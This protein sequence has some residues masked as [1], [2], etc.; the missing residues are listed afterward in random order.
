MEEALTANMEAVPCEECQAK[1]GSKPEPV[2]RMSLRVALPDEEA[3]AFLL[4]V[5]NLVETRGF[6]LIS[7]EKYAY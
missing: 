7:F 2:T 3:L 4:L 5:N 6:K 1:Q